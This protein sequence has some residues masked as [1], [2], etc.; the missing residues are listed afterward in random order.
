M[1]EVETVVRTR[2]VGGSIMATIPKNAVDE[3]DI[4]GNQLLR[5]KIKKAP[6]DFFGA[7]R[8]IGPFLPEDESDSHD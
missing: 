1:A 6:K 4:R 5:L 8:G 3:L 7:L 2:K